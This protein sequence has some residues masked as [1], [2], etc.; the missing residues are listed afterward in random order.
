MTEDGSQIAQ[1]WQVFDLP[2]SCYLGNRITKKMLLENDSLSVSDKKLITE[3]LDRL[4]WQYTLKPETI[5][6]APFQSED[7]DYREI[8][9][10]YGVLRNSHRAKKLSE[11]LQ[12]LIPYPLLL[13]LENEDN[14]RL[15]LAM[16]RQNLAD[17]QKLTVELFFDSEWLSEVSSKE[18]IELFIQSLDSKQFSWENFYK[19]YL[20]LIERVLA[21][22]KALITGQFQLSKQIVSYTELISQQDKLTEYQRL[23]KE[24]NILRKRASSSQQMGKQVELNTRIHGLHQSIATLKGSL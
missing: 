21:L 13:I 2:K 15:S 20:S 24:V 8:A 3:D 11:V 4:H 12:R 6:I 18:V 5:T 7:L 19:F 23:C 22:N 17:K 9:V 16:K 1:L 14:L 10:L